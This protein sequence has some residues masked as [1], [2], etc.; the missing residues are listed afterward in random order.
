MAGTTSVWVEERKNR[1]GS[2]VVRKLMGETKRDLE[3][4]F[5]LQLGLV[6]S[7]RFHSCSDT[8]FDIERWQTNDAAFDVDESRIR[9]TR[10]A[11]HGR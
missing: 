3:R 1:I 2:G 6:P 9:K 11:E 7:R 4:F 10:R 5:A 8:S